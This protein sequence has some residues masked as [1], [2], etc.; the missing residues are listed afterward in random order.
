MTAIGRFIGER[1]ITLSDF[2]SSIFAGANLKFPDDGKYIDCLKTSVLN[3]PKLF[4]SI[5]TSFDFKGIEPS[6]IGQRICRSR[7]SE[8]ELLNIVLRK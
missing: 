7:K 4:C 5:V 6:G 1:A 3:G 2:I 8:V